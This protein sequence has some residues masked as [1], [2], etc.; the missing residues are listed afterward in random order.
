MVCS[1]HLRGTVKSSAGF[2]SNLL[3]FFYFII[4]ISFRIEDMHR[5]Q[6]ESS[7]PVVTNVAPA[8]QTTRRS[9]MASIFGELSDGSNKLK[10]DTN[11]QPSVPAKE[12]LVTVT[13]ARIANLPAPVSESSSGTGRSFLPTFLVRPSFSFS[14]FYY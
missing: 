6:T 14:R 7:P 4:N 5:E 11:Q 12:S 1:R 3:I 10:I 13:V 2:L 9:L 8:P